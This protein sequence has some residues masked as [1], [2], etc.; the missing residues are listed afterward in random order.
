MASTV[1][2]SILIA[3]LLTALGSIKD[4]EVPDMLDTYSV[5]NLNNTSQLDTSSPLPV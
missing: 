5:F 3:R 4:F 2:P 1:R